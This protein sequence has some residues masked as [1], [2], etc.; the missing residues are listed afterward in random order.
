MNLHPKKFSDIEVVDL[1]QGDD[2]SLYDKFKA[3]FLNI[4]NVY[5]DDPLISNYED[6]DTFFN[7][8]S[9]V[10][11]CSKDSELLGFSSLLIGRFGPSWARAL[12]RT[13]YFNS[14]RQSPYQNYTFPSLATGLM[15]PL[16][17]ECASRLKLDGIFISMQG[18]RGKKVMQKLADSF[19]KTWGKQVWKF[20]VGQFNT[21]RKIGSQLNQ[22]DD[23]WQYIAYLQ[24]KQDAKFPLPAKTN[25]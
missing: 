21:C 17:I 14:F 1:K 20:P 6:F 7:E 16:Q 13:F 8:S 4:K 25:H 11:V 24:L 19:E 9:S 12:N 15:L 3:E 18:V 23:C 5:I 22:E 10:T 2:K